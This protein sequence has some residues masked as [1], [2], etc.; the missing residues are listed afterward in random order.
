MWTESKLKN[1]ICETFIK[2][3][4]DFDDYNI[5]VAING[6]LTRTLGRCMFKRVNGVVT[7][8]RIEF[9]RQFLESSTDN[10]VE[11][12]IEHE[13]CHA[14]VT[15]ETKEDHGHDYEFKAMCARVGCTNDGKST[16]VERT[17]DETELYKYFVKCRK[18][19]KVIGKYHRAGKVI[20][21]PD[22]YGCPYC[23]KF[24]VLEVVQN[25]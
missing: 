17:V 25:F 9:S 19:G 21:Y 11:S 6:R 16:K 22:H 23:K 10:C 2:A 4:Y 20:Q 8:Y 14:L 5:E 12:V 13:A 1:H 24:G 15:I 18:C 3:G 7:P